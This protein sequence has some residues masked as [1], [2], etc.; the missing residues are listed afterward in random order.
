MAKERA[1]ELGLRDEGH[2]QRE[3]EALRRFLA[4]RERLQS[5]GLAAAEADQAALKETG[6]VQRQLVSLFEPDQPHPAC[7]M[8]SPVPAGKPQPI[9]PWPAPPRTPPAWLRL[10]PAITLAIGLAAGFF[11]G[12]GWAGGEPPTAP[13]PPPETLIV[14]RPAA[15]SA[16]LETARRGDQL[17]DL[18]IRNRHS[19][20]AELLVAYH[21]ASR[22]CAR[23]TV[24]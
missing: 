2:R 23:D 6:P 11:L 24:P 22:Q 3:L 17:L 10:V 20:A 5:D 8:A 18:L 13:A 9:T 14:V 21:V 15:T 16:C 12:S 19:R 4:T 7:S 1:A